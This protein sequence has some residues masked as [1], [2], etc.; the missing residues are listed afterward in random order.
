MC[1]S[2][3]PLV[4]GYD[5]VLVCLLKHASDLLG[6]AKEQSGGLIGVP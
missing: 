1:I 2:E 6:L 5:H 4:V 3:H